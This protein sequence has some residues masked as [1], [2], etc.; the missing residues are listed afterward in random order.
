MG[1]ITGYISFLRGM[2]CIEIKRYFFSGRWGVI[3]WLIGRAGI[4]NLWRKRELEL[5]K[6]NTPDSPL[7]ATIGTD[8]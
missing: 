4:L 1:F 2:E 6:C 3:I 8:F 5:Q 7:I